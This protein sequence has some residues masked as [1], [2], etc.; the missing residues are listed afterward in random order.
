MD[1][2][3]KRIEYFLSRALRPNSYE[4]LAAWAL[5]INLFIYFVRPQAIV[6]VLGGIRLPL[7]FV[8]ICIV[9][10]LPR[11]NKGW[12]AQTLAMLAFI[13]FEGIMGFFGRVVVDSLIVND[14]WHFHTW[15]DL[16]MQFFALI[17]PFTAIFVCGVL[18][19]RTSYA[20]MIVGASMGLH[21]IT[22]AGKGPPGWS[23]DEND[24]CYALLLFLPFALYKV[25]NG[26]KLLPRLFALLCLAIIGAG[27]VMT[28]SRGG[29]LGLIAAL[30]YLFVKSPS[31]LRTITFAI[32]L[33]AAA[34][35]FVPETY[36]KEMQTI[37]ETDKGTAGHRRRFWATATRM[38]LD[39]QNFLTGVGMGNVKYRIRDYE[40]VDNLRPTGRSDAGRSVHS[41]WF[42]TIADL[43]L[44]GISLLLF[45][46]FKTYK[47][48]T[49]VLGELIGVEKQIKWLSEKKQRTKVQ[50]EALGYLRSMESELKELLSLF[51]SATMAGV[52]LLGA[53]TFISVLYYPPLW[54]LIA[55]CAALSA[56]WEKLSAPLQELLEIAGDNRET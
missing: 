22:H 35:P 10:W 38:W 13:I 14:F 39:P 56:Y 24:M 51:S 37:T 47:Q 30:G 50:E 45:V 20:C 15:R 54:F 42:Q 32:V 43:G 1:E 25:I 28:S 5:L 53:G 3:F 7:I 9:F 46:I 29:F 2:P 41:I 16:S 23:G 33:L 31:K 17:F 36:W 52:G 11:Y 21:S 34:I 48:N 40:P 8:I 26:R 27:I 12:T 49:R 44:V 18:L 6:P 4:S 19:K 55:F